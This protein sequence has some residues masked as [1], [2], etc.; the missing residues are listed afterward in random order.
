MTEVLGYERYGAHGGDTGSPISQALARS[1]PESVVGIHLTDIG[2]DKVM[3]LDPSTF[4][5]AEQEYANSLEQVVVRGGRVRHDPGHQAADAC[6]YGLNDS[7]AGLAAWIVEKFRTWSDCEGDVERSFT[8]DEL[9][10]NVT[11]YWATQTINSSIRG[12][13]EGMHSWSEPEPRLEAPV[14]LALF[15]KDNPPPREMAERFFDVR[16]WT[17][18]PRG[19][20]FAAMEEPELLAEELQAF[21]RDLR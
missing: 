6:G 17:E 7:P 19:G 4:S 12:Y 3:Q 8:K 13:Y 16:R 11:I 14:G 20:H 1:H 21:Y 2:Y 18:M 15:P 9:L 5:E 10:T